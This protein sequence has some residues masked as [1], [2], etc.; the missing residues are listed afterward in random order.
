MK[1]ISEREKK[2]IERYFDENF[3]V[4]S[5]EARRLG[6]RAVDHYI[7]IGEQQGLSPNADFDPVFYAKKNPDVANSKYT[8]FGHYALYGLAEGRI[9][10][11]TVSNLAYDDSKFD[12]N[13]DTVLV[14]AHEAT[15]TGAPILGL[16]IINE[17]RDSYNVIAVVMKTGSILPS[18]EKSAAATIII[19][20]GVAL[21]GWEGKALVEQLVARYRPL[22]AVANSSVTKSLAVHLEQFGVPVVAL[23]HEFAMDS[24][25]L[26]SLDE[27]YQKASHIVFPTRIV[28]EDSQ[29]MYPLLRGRNVL[30]FPQ[31]PS[32]IPAKSD[33]FAKESGTVD[34]PF[35]KDGRFTVF[36]MGTITYRKGVD[37]FVSV[38]DFLYRELNRDDFRFIWIGHHNPGDVRY[39]LAIEAHIK[40]SGLE[41]VF[42]FLDEVDDLTPYFNAADLL[43]LSS[44]IDPLP[45]VAIDAALAGVPILCFKD[46]TG[47]ADILEQ[48]AATSFL[49]AP[50]VRVDRAAK[51]IG[52]LIDKRAESS[53]LSKSL[54]Q[55][56][57]K[58]FDMKSYVARIDQLGRQAASAIK[59]IES[60]VT[61]VVDAKAF[62]KAF[63]FGEHGLAFD[64]TT[65]V[66]RY[67]NGVRLA[68]PLS[69]R[70]AGIFV[71][72]PMV[73]FNPLIYDLNNPNDS[74][75]FRD[76]LTDFL[77]KGKPAGPWS[78]YVIRPSEAVLEPNLRVAVHGHFHYTDLLDEFLQCLEVNETKPDLFIT[79]TSE[80]KVREIQ[81]TLGKTRWSA[82]DVWT[83]PNK[84]RD[85]FSFIKDMPERLGRHYDIVGHLHGKKSGHVET[86]VGDRWRN[87]AWQ[88]LLGNKYPMLDIIAAAFADHPNIGLVFPEDPHLNGWDLNEAVGIELAKRIGLTKPLPTHFDFPI[89]T[90]FWARPEALKPLFEMKLDLSEIPAEP[91]PID[92]TIL[93]ALERLIPFAVEKAGFAYATTHV[94]GVN[95]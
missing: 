90:M 70:D 14:L 36:G 26:G 60:D 80:E 16:N 40:K 15:R 5:Q 43:F 83:V 53:A 79:T 11:S 25:P 64:D 86:A 7:E 52:D 56:A 20:P 82:K 23:V 81:A 45:N 47:F 32:V 63:Y 24:P 94:A 12:P 55:Y 39:K 75:S 87:F 69:R 22:Y 66:K 4:L 37:L 76:P 8:L 18:F 93:H 95:R 33:E 2:A 44:R 31:G 71:R 73:G 19:P 77:A 92:G 91:L 89:G 46:A 28:A 68:W 72:R 78:H 67:M 88:H 85:I 84:G 42:E 58:T 61:R 21:D 49:V 9:S 57:K 35:A 34:R 51:I 41:S 65:A 10:R 30:V 17:L 54:K 59:Q 3:Y 1:D 62:D 6:M 38:A 50:Y 13:L 29:A 48:D 74:G 27:L